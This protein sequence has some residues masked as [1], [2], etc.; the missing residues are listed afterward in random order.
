[1]TRRLL[2]AGVDPGT[3]LGYALLDIEGNI[4]KLKSS[5]QLD[6]NTLIS[7]IISYGIPI[8][9]GTDRKDIPGFIG[10]LGRKLGARIITSEKDMPVGYKKTITKEFEKQYKDEHQRDALAGALYALRQIKS[11]LEKIERFVRENH[12]EGLKD[13]LITLVLKNEIS[14]KLALEILESPESEESKIVKKAIDEKK[15]DSDFLK[16]Y[17]QL[18]RAKRES[19]FLKE[20]NNKLEKQ[21]KDINK[22]IGYINNKI[23]HLKPDEKAQEQLAFK[24]NRIKTIAREVESKERQIKELSETILDLNEFIIQLPDNILVKKLKNLGAVEYE[25]KRNILKIKKGDILFVEDLS[26]ISQKTVDL[27][28]NKADII[29]FKGNLNKTLEKEFILINES[30]LNLKHTKHFALVDKKELEKEKINKKLLAKV[31]EDY[32]KERTG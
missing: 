13:E 24:E 5:K 22:K 1:M 11:L 30:R 28:K 12:K 25:S 29:I 4:V 10:K 32:K 16:L 21:L 2:I 9:I 8:F 17:D 7:E 26:I 27:L 31:I 20:Q 15:F 23:K 6:L 19:S 14:I 3:T 18:K